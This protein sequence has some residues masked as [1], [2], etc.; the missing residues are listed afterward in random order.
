[1]VSLLIRIGV[2]LGLLG[3]IYLLARKRIGRIVLAGLVGLV[4]IG[5]VGRAR[6]RETLLQ[7]PV[8][9]VTVRQAAQVV[10]E[11]AGTVR[12]V[13]IYDPSCGVCRV[14]VPQIARYVQHRAR[15]GVRLYAFALTS[16]ANDVRLMLARDPDAFVGYRLLPYQLGELTS[17]MATVNVVVPQWFTP[18]IV[19][20]LAPDGSRAGSWESVHDLTDLSLVV[21][22]LVTARE[23]V[24]A[25]AH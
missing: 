1:M 13:V 5:L 23:V 12:A 3:V 21:D 22:S 15:D 4:V 10:A 24:N 20:V 18:P 9:D 25:K 2:A 11:G 17:S 6:A 19:T 16:D 14:M 8:H 7:I